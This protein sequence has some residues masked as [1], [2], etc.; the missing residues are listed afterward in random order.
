[1]LSI[2]IHAIE[3]PLARRLEAT[4]KREGKSLNQT[5]KDILASSLGLRAAPKAKVRNDLS[6][7]CGALSDADAKALR[8]NLKAFE[9]IDEEMWK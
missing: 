6:R 5:V 4:A 1:M 9:Q 3:E 8:E 2:T 7:F